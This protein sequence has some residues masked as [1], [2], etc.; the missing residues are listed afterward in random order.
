MHF[1]IAK[2]LFFKAIAIC[3]FAKKDPQKT[4]PSIEILISYK[5]FSRAQI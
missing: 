2:L 3:N 5:N 1:S 4:D